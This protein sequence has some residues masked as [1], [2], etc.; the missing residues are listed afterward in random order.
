[1][2]EQRVHQTTLEPDG[3]TLRWLPWTIGLLC[4]TIF[5]ID[6]LTPLG[7]ATPMLY[8]F[9]LALTVGTRKP[10]V[11]WG[12]ALL[13]SG[14]TLIGYHTSVSGGVVPF[15]V[16]NRSFSVVVFFAAAMLI[17]LFIQHLKR[18]RLVEANEALLAKTQIQVV[19]SAPNGMLLAN[20]AGVITMVNTQ[21][22]HLFGYS[23]QELLGQP[24]EV[25]IPERFKARHPEQRTAFFH[26]P[27]TRS[28]GAGRELF[29][30]R[31]DASEFPLEIGLN[32]IQT[33]QGRQ[34]L[35]A[36]VDITDRKTAE[37]KLQQAAADLAGCGKTLV[38][39]VP[40]G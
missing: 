22:E 37:L 8:L 39:S 25:L 10:Q 6:F 21:I 14:L 13:S 9:P 23:R 24:V 29:G 20:Q 35:A 11:A 15:A 28:M 2:T 17:Q 4:V 26:S 1:M 7:I 12:V 33:P 5:G 34:V 31:K 16:I 32:P 18:V 36:I 19:E 40:S 30:R 3:S 27:S 38:F